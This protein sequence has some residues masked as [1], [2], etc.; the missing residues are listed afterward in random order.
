[1]LAD[2]KGVIKYED[3]NLFLTFNNKYCTLKKMTSSLFYWILMGKQVNTPSCIAKWREMW[4]ISDLEWKDI[5]SRHFKICHEAYLQTLQY[6][7]LHRIIPCNHW[8]F[9]IKVKNS[10]NCT[11]CNVDDSIIHY[12]YDCKRV[13]QYWTSFELWWIRVTGDEGKLDAP[14]VIFGVNCKSNNAN[15]F[16]YCLIIAKLYIYKTKQKSD[17][18]E[19][20]FYKYLADLKSKL[21]VEEMSACIKDRYSKFEKQLNAFIANFNCCHV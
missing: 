19:I 7:I 21:I 1:M 16:N 3:I 17:S 2:A 8:L 15:M 11:L 18:I 13:K 9:N 12:F 14:T 6:K 5:F 4:N 20:D 10:T